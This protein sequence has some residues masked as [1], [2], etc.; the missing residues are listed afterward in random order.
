MCTVQYKIRISALLPRYIPGFAVVVR[1]ELPDILPDCPGISRY[2]GEIIAT[3]LQT[4]AISVPPFYFFSTR[5]THFDLIR[6][7]VCMRLT[8]R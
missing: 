1:A 7:F 5:D 2:V 4:T 6:R 3:R 8:S